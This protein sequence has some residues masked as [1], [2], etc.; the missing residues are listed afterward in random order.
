MCV[1]CMYVCT[2]I[3]RKHMALE[4]TKSFSEQLCY[5]PF[6]GFQWLF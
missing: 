2:T 3:P 1:F 6:K 5:S 4:R